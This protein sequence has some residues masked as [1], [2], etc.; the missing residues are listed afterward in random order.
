MPLWRKSFRLTPAAIFS[1]QGS[2]LNCNIISCA[3][4][5]AK[6]P[7]NAEGHSLQEA[8]QDKCVDY[9]RRVGTF[10]VMS[11][12]KCVV[13]LLYD[14]VSPY[15]YVGFELITRCSRE[16]TNMDLRLRPVLA[17]GIFKGLGIDHTKFVNTKFSPTSESRARSIYVNLYNKS[18]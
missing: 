14:V 6:K 13:E 10:L 8:T 9:R 3:T 11:P 7:K 17:G 18:T 4:T 1:L 2:S 15:S 12:R 16:W 5:V